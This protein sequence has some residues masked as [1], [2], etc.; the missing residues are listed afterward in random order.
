LNA[1]SIVALVSWQGN[2]LLL[3]GD[4]EA[5]VLEEY[6]LP[7]VEVLVVGHHGSRAAVSS[8]LLETLGLRAAV[9]SVGKN[10]SYGHPDPATISLL[11]DA[12]GTVL[13]TDLSGWVS[14]AVHHDGMSVTTEK[15]V[16]F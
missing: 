16:G 4:A 7:S 3:P 5:E 15:G 2:D 13:R 8:D 14:F 11:G 1:G 9:I 10:N 12:V 6:D